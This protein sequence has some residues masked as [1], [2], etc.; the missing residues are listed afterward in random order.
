MT[1][2]YPSDLLSLRNLVHD[3][4]LALQ[5]SAITMERNHKADHLRGAGHGRIG[6]VIRS[7]ARLRQDYTGF[8]AVL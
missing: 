4:E 1:W 8:S 3:L 5:R 2:A 6:A 7:P